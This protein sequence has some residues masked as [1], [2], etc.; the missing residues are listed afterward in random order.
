MKTKMTLAMIL[1]VVAFPVL[2]VMDDQEFEPPTT[3]PYDRSVYGFPLTDGFYA[4]RAG[5]KLHHGAWDIAVPA[6]TAVYSPLEGVAKV[7]DDGDGLGLYILIEQ[8]K[9][10]LGGVVAGPWGF[11]VGHL[12]EPQVLSGWE[13]KRGQLIGFSGASGCARGA[14]IHFWITYK[15]RKINPADVIEGMKKRK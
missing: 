4:P 7:K 12:S 6:G 13:I 14:H 5:G 11:G 9:N 15:G 1:F 10:N 8:Q 2:A 3:L